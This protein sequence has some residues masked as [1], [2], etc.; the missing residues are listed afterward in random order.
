MKINASEKDNT[1][2]ESLSAGQPILVPEIFPALPLSRR[3]SVFFCV[4]PL[5]VTLGIL[6][7]P[8]EFPTEEPRIPPLVSR[9]TL[10]YFPNRRSRL[11]YSEM[12]SLK[13]SGAKSG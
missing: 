5:Y 8:R 2:T 4:E 11:P 9:P 13:D 3:I 6:S 7:N 1:K 12:A 10:G